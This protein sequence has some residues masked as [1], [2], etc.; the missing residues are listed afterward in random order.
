[1]KT[2]LKLAILG[3]GAAVAL[4]FA[5]QA[6]WWSQHPGYLHAMSDLRSAYWLISH[7]E[8]F[9][10]AA[11]DEERHALGEIRAAYGDLKQAAIVD[12]KDIDDQPPADFRFEDHRGRLRHAL[13]LLHKAHNDIASEEDN[14]AARGLRDRSIR[15]IDDAGRWTDAALHAWHF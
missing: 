3:A 14:P 9:D 7:H 2:S 10:P 1:M 8:T 11:N 12:N 13:D 5:A 15:H 6:Q 4:P